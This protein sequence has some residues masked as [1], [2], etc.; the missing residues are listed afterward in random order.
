[1]AA[2]QSAG[3]GAGNGGERRGE[4]CSG[5]AA[6]TAA[7]AAAARLCGGGERSDGARA[8]AYIGRERRSRDAW[9]RGKGRR[10]RPGLDGGGGVGHAWRDGAVGSWAAAWRD[11]GPAQSAK[12]FF[13]RK[14]TQR[15][16]T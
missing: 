9:R 14:K 2:G 12:R 5:G 15:K 7:D 10:A 6:T 1:M 16:I 11:A 8:S 13:F 4:R 3:G